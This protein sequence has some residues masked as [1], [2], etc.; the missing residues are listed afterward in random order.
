MDYENCVFLWIEKKY[1][2]YMR[3]SVRERVESVLFGHL[4]PE[5]RAKAM[6]QYVLI[7]KGFDSIRKEVES[8]GKVPGWKLK[9]KVK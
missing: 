6:A 1:G 8:A 3:D 5:E 2:D 7:D 9:V 4:S